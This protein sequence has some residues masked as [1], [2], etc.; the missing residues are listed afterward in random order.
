MT[1]PISREVDEEFKGMVEWVRRIIQMKF[2]ETEVSLIQVSDQEHPDQRTGGA[3]NM[4]F[5]RASSPLSVKV[6]RLI[7]LEEF[8]NQFGLSLEEQNHGLKELQ[9]KLEKSEEL[10][11]KHENEIKNLRGF[12][13]EL[14]KNRTHYKEKYNKKIK[15]DSIN[16]KE[17]V[18]MKM[19]LKSSQSDYEL[20]VNEKVKLSKKVMDLESQL[21]EHS[22]FIR[23]FKSCDKND[24]EENP[25][26]D[27]N[28]EIC[29]K[30]PHLLFEIKN[31]KES[32]SVAE[33][34]V[35]LREQELDLLK[36]KLPSSQ[37]EN[38]ADISG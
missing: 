6:A 29:L 34:L 3:S 32:L 9:E 16:E 5:I 7:I 37:E 13:A 30:C 35:S 4:M 23:I 17:F 1:I 31:L 19:K 14:E 21:E 8:K 10:V 26:E 36:K 2:P 28:K 24:N 11:K 18:K 12:N 33:G 38:N 22:E 25:E 20:V 15:T 27:Q